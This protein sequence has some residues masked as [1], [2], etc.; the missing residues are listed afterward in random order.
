MPA[1]ERN[2]SLIGRIDR[3]IVISLASQPVN[4]LECEL[5]NDLV[6]VPEPVDQ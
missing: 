6:V 5:P 2:L 3:P 1:V 4:V